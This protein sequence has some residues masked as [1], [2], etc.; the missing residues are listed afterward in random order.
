MECTIVMMEIDETFKSKFIVS[1]NKIWE[2]NT[3]REIVRWG[4]CSTGKAFAVQ[5][6]RCEFG[7]LEPLQ[8]HA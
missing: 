5:V 2:E 1:I 8:S 6:W 7:S 3:K 4:E